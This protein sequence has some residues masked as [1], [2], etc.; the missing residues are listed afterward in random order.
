MLD[1]EHTLGREHPPEPRE[2]A[3]AGQE[4]GVPELEDPERAHHEP[5]CRERIVLHLLEAGVEKRRQDRPVPLLRAVGERVHRRPADEVAL[6]VRYAPARL[7]RGGARLVRVGD[8]RIVEH[9]EGDPA[10]HGLTGAAKVR[11]TEALERG[12]LVNVIKD[13]RACERMVDV[14]QA[15]PAVAHRRTV[16][17]GFVV[18]RVDAIEVRLRDVADEGERITPEAV[19]ED[20]QHRAWIRERVRA[21]VKPRHERFAAGAAIISTSRLRPARKSSMRSSSGFRAFDI[22]ETAPGARHRANARRAFRGA[23]THGR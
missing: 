16:A 7:D 4:A 14:G 10:Q 21:A 20:V 15:D 6:F 5:S 11:A 19:A 12:A 3:G 1:R 22:R 17:P 8:G 13:E 9:A 2:Q 23:P 18:Q